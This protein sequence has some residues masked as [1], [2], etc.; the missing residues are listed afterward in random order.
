MDQ[1]A[2]KQSIVTS[3]LIVVLVFLSNLNDANV[4]P[5]SKRISVAFGKSGLRTESSLRWLVS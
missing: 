5:V 1:Y 3:S 4:L 2:E